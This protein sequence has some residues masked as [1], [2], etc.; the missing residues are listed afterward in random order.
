MDNRM[1]EKGRY[2]S[3][4]QLFT[5][6]SSGNS[7]TIIV[8]N[9]SDSNRK[10]FVDS[11]KVNVESKAYIKKY[12]NVTYS[13]STNTDTGIVNKNSGNN[14]SSDAN[15]YKN[16]SS[17][18]G[19]RQFSD[20]LI[21]GGPS[22]NATGGAE[23]IQAANVITEGDNLLLEITNKSST[24]QDIAVDIDWVERINQQK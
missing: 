8:E 15:V 2:F 14:F 21:G 16:V 1:L 5:G 18:S 12:F 9:P 7:V 11:Q 10:F 3:T 6:I 23:S 17:F 4:G 20:K 19:G 13:G 22:P 24:P